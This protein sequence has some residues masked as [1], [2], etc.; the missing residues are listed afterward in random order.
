MRFYT[1]QHPFY[2][3]IDLHT[4]TMHACILDHGCNWRCYKRFSVFSRGKGAFLVH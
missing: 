3:G 2:C 1:N 4:R